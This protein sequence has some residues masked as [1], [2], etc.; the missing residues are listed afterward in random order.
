MSE[1]KDEELVYTNPCL[2]GHCVD[3]LA[4]AGALGASVW[5]GVENLSVCVQVV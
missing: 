1:G 2:G 3:P 5:C 4:E